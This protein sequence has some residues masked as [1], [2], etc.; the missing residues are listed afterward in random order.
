MPR[1]SVIS[2]VESS[3]FAWDANAIGAGWVKALDV[4]G[5]G[6]VKSLDPQA[7]GNSTLDHLMFVEQWAAHS[8]TSPI[9][10]I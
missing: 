7:K 8:L 3:F 5:A 4:I 2:I 6:R 9:E 10:W 1:W